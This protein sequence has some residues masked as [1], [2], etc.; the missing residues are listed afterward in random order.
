MPKA[1][2]ST[3]CTFILPFSS[4]LHSPLFLLSHVWDHLTNKLPVHK[5]LPQV[6]LPGEMQA[7]LMVEQKDQGLWSWTDLSLFISSATFYLGDLEQVTTS[8][9]FS[10]FICKM[11]KRILT[12]HRWG[13]LITDK[14]HA[15]LS[16]G[17]V[18]ISP[19]Q[20]AAITVI[21]A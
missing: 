15:V 4:F 10:F 17:S 8:P 19:Q 16:T 9:S 18:S 7:N 20:I 5:S 12:L 2:T 6:L 13:I 3:K 11:G 14:N 1:V 21:A